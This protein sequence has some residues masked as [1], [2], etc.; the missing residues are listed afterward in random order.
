MS[1]VLIKAATEKIIEWE[2][3]CGIVEHLTRN[4]I[5]DIARLAQ[6]V[7]PDG[8]YDAWAESLIELHM[9][10]EREAGEPV[11]RDQYDA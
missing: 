11:S 9:E 10:A 1:M 2:F 4:E 7:F 6:V 3:S 5:A 8:K